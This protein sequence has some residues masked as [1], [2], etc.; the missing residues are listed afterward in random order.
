M[1]KYCGSNFENTTL[2]LVEFGKM[3]KEYGFAGDK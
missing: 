3:L 2:C 1:K